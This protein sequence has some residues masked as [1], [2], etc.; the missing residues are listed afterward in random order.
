MRTDGV[1]FASIMRCLSENGVLNIDVEGLTE[2]VSVMNR[3]FIES[4]DFLGHFFFTFFS[5][6][7]F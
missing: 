1:E 3:G 4:D 5:T 7:V 6:H 2:F